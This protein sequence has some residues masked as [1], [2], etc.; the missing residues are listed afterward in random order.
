[1]KD[2]GSEEELSLRQRERA[3]KL[4]RRL[5]GR[6]KFRG[7][8]QDCAFYEVDGVT[9]TIGTQGGYGIPSVRTYEEGLQSALNAHSLWQKQ[10]NRDT[11]DLS[12]AAEYLTGHL[13]AT[14]GSNWK[15]LGNVECPCWNEHTDRRKHMSLGKLQSH[16]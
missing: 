6:I 8:N 4:K 14:V 10:Q 9:V 3:E 7:A 5:N 15:C 11:R 12:R 2:L 13:N 1:M 16:A